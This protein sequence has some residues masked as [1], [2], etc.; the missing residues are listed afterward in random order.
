MWAPNPGMNQKNWW[1]PSRPSLV[2]FTGTIHMPQHMFPTAAEIGAAS[3]AMP[4][5]APC[6][7]ALAQ[8]AAEVGYAEVNVNGNIMLTTPV[9]AAGEHHLFHACMLST[10]G[11]QYDE[12]WYRPQLAGALFAVHAVALVTCLR[13]NADEQAVDMLYTCEHLRLVS[14]AGARQDIRRLA[15]CIGSDGVGNMD[16]DYL[17][18]AI[19]CRWL[20]VHRAARTIQ[21]AL[22]E[23]V[24]KKRALARTDLIRMEL[25]ERTWRPD[26]WLVRAMFAEIEPIC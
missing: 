9:F 10:R 5:L 20:R 26:S 1:S 15:N 7:A 12:R 21:H 22:R 14:E 4:P 6:W 23:L 25:M 17:V 16:W 19:L 18:K 8:A 2:P 3:R 11:F 24:A 13:K